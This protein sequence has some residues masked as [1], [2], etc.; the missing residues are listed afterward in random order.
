MDQIP[1]WRAKAGPLVQIALSVGGGVRMRLTAAP[2]SEPTQKGTKGST[3]LN[4]D[5]ADCSRGQAG[6]RAPWPKTQR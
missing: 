4:L 5:L 6:N 3:T 1:R 2:I